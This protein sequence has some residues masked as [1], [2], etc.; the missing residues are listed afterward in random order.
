MEIHVVVQLQIIFKVIQQKRKYV[1]IQ[2]YT[3]VQLVA[4]IMATITTHKFAAMEK[5]LQ[6]I[7]YQLLIIK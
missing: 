4:A 2:Q 5:L 7:K 1:A 3:L 6:A